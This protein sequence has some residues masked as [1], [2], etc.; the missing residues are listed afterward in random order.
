MHVPYYDKGGVKITKELL[1]VP[2]GRNF[3]VKNIDSIS[4]KIVTPNYKNP[5]ICLVV[6]IILLAVY[7]LG[8]ILIIAGILWW[9]SQKN[10]YYIYVTTAGNEGEAYHSYDI[11]EIREVRSALNAAI[12]AD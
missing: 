1:E 6:G 3:S 9:K 12:E 4:I 8:I 5:I 7:G 10:I 11:E 2:S